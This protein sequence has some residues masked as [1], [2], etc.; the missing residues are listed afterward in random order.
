MEAAR[1][2]SIEFLDPLCLRFRFGVLARGVFG[3][4]EAF[5]KILG[6]AVDIILVR[7]SGA[8]RLLA[9]LSLRLGFGIIS[10]V[11]DRAIRTLHRSVPAVEIFLLNF[12][13]EVL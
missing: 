7:V 9:T 2:L 1:E 12:V 13:D 3:L 4:V 8:A 6:G 10:T 11:N 5:P